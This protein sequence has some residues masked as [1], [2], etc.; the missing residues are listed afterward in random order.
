MLH[1]SNVLVTRSKHKSDQYIGIA[2]RMEI[3]K[4]FWKVF[5]LLEYEMSPWRVVLVLVMTF[6]AV[7]AVFLPNFVLRFLEA[8]MILISQ[9][10]LCICTH[11]YI[12]YS[13]LVCRHTF[14][15]I[16]FLLISSFS[17]LPHCFVYSKYW[18]P[19]RKNIKPSVN[20]SIV[21]IDATHRK[22]NH[23]RRAPLTIWRV[24]S[25]LLL[26]LLLPPLPVECKLIVAVW[27]LWQEGRG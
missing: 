9:R 21:K 2:R 19:N 17:S 27:G 15:D 3:W 20:W 4:T 18:K 13:S 16:D 26:L 12:S 25:V 6:C 8:C 1:C 23:E 14:L 7:F 11:F 5:L 24:S 22:L 10:Y